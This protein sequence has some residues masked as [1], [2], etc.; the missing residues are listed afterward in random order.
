MKDRNLKSIVNYSIVKLNCSGIFKLS[1]KR[2][3]YHLLQ[4]L[5]LSIM[6]K[7]SRFV[8]KLLEIIHK[9][10]NKCKILIRQ[11]WLSKKRT[12]HK[13]VITANDRK[14]KFLYIATVK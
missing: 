11:S 10:A 7:K 3:K 1:S 6:H 2:V 14:R 9:L 8:W 13:F 4:K 12:S 5:L